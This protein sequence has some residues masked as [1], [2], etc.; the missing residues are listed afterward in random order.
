MINFFNRKA[1][2]DY[3]LQKEFQYPKV[4]DEFINNYIENRLLAQIRWYSEKSQKCQI[5]YKNLS[6]CSCILST[7]LPFFIMLSE[8]N[9][10][11]F[12]R[13][14]IAALGG[15]VTIISFILSITN[16]KELWVKYRSSCELLKSLLH[17]YYTNSGRFSYCNTEEE[18]FQYLVD[19]SE[20][21]LTEEF[22][23]WATMQKDQHPQSIKS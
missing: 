2:D 7:C 19:D 8:E 9:Y 3:N 22:K 4:K 17:E 23:S 15:S 1:K 13:L 10:T 18:K 16:D 12:I 5:N 21:L 11:L 6:V 20:S 14:I